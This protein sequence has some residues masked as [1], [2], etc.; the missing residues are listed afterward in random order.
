MHDIKAFIG[1]GALAGL[2]GGVFGAVFQ[3]I[4]TE[5][6]IRAALAIE[7]ANST[8]HG[9][10]MFS[11]GTQVFGGMAAFG[12][13]GLFIGVVFGIACAALWATLPGSS[14]FAR[15]I[16]LA[17]A[18]FV[19]WVLVPALKYPA[20]P[21]AVGDPD[22][23]GQRTSAFLL[24]MALSLALAYGAWELWRQ[25]SARG[26]HGAER[27]A[28]VVGGYVFAIGI[29]YVGFP[30]NPDTI[31]VPAKLIWQFRLDSLAGNALLWIVMGVA[32]GYLGDRAARRRQL[33]ATRDQSSLPL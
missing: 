22:T 3:W 15:S 26:W 12:L 17:T 16:R 32:F 14:V 19:A 18:G 20:N 21:P 5:D 29:I 24:L 28:V 23:V 13:Y 2:T 27:F 33:D 11:R 4:F 25:L 6:Q 31:E 9:D 30:S 1:R 10:E 7:A 8:G